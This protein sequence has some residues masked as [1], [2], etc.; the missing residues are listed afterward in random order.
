MTIHYAR[1]YCRSVQ[2][3]DTRARLSTRQG[4]MYDRGGRRSTRRGEMYDRPSRMCRRHYRMPARFA[5][6]WIKHGD[7]S[8]LS[9]K[10]GVNQH[11]P[12]APR[13]SASSPHPPPPRGVEERVPEGRE[14]RHSPASQAVRQRA[15]AMR[16]QSLQQGK[17]LREPGRRFLHLLRGEGEV[18]MRGAVQFLF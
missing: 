9:L 3:W 17:I 8:G 11:E 15:I 1:L 18:R 2:H 14:R 10:T 6:L 7:W 5:H 4:R 13:M 12:L 16:K